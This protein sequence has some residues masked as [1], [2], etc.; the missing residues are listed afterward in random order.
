MKSLIILI[1]FAAFF[2]VDISLDLRDGVAL[3][4][5]WH[6]VILFFLAIGAITWQVRVIF[7]NNVHISRL[8]SELLATKKSYQEW[9]EKTHTSAKEIR[10]LIDSEFTLWQLSLSEKDVALLLIKGL[11]MKEIATIRDT[12]EK[13]VRQQ[14]TTVYKKSGLSGRQELAAYFLE[15]ILSLPINN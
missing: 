3:S 15:D 6:E 1:L 7:K 2:V 13:T 8:N 14:A 11:S 4:H 5:V 10:Q 12:Q 9:K